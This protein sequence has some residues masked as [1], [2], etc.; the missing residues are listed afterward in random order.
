MERG[1]IGKLGRQTQAL[2]LE[3]INPLYHSCHFLLSA[4]SIKDAPPDAG[5][6]VAFAGR[7]NA[8]KSSAIN[9][10]TSQRSLARTSK[11]PGRTQLINFFAVDGSRRLVDLPGYGY[12]KVSAARRNAWHRA[13]EEYLMQRRCL[14]GIFLMMDIRHPLNPLDH[15]TVGWCRELQ[16]PVHL[17]LTKA[18]KLGRGAAKIVL[19]QVERTLRSAGETQASVQ[20]FSSISRLGL[21]EAHNALDRL[22]QTE[23]VGATSAQKSSEALRGDRSGAK[24]PSQGE[25][26][27]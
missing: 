19:L 22:L 26:G 20:L 2:R 23:D 21:E 10:I 4:G 25:T 13:V 3:V 27:R 12:A 15:Q 1:N 14:R 8:G 18:D 9:T 5:A 7:S 6:E 16:I 17:L 24:L 11:T